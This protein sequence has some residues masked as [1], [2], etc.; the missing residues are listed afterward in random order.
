MKQKS[1]IAER[2][3]AAL[4]RQEA[5]KCAFNELELGV[6]DLGKA[7]ESSGSTEEARKAHSDALKMVEFFDSEV[8]RRDEEIVGLN[9]E[10]KAIDNAL[11]FL[12]TL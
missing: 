3:K 11:E 2:K 10:E 5:A 1:D 8:M 6:N 12:T 9:E 4:E 7:L